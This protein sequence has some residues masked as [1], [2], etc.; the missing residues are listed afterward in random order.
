MKIPEEKM[1]ELMKELEKGLDGIFG[2]IA[3][4]KCIKGSGMEA[5]M[6]DTF[7]EY[8]IIQL[9]VKRIGSEVNVSKCSID[10]VIEALPNAIGS[11]LGLIPEDKRN[12]VLYKAIT[13]NNMTKDGGL[14]DRLKER[15]E[16]E[17]EEED[18]PEE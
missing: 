7:M 17:E 1:D 3:N 11:L 10:D 18:Y 4:V 12:E 5:K 13:E 2:N 9:T 16:D 15:Y 6:I 14:K 8:P